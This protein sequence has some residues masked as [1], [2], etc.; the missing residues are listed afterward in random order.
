M[1]GLF[2]ACSAAISSNTTNVLRTSTFCKFSAYRWN[3]SVNH[4]GAGSV[5]F[6]WF[7]NSS[8]IRL[9]SSKGPRRKN[10]RS[11]KSGPTLATTPK[12]NEEGDSF[13]VVRKGDLIGIYKNLSDCQT[14][15]GSSICDPPVSVFKGHSMPKDTEEYLLSRGLKNALYTV[16]AQDV[17]EDLFDTLEPCHLQLSS[18]SGGMPNDHMAKKRS[19][20]AMWPDYTD[21]VAGPAAARPTGSS[22]RKPAML[23]KTDDTALSLGSCSLEFDGASKGNPGQ[24][25]AGAVLRADDGSLTIKLREGLGMTTNNVAEYRAI[26]LGLRCALS[27]GFTRIRAQGDSKLVCMQI[28]GLWKVKNENI[29]TLYEQAKQLKDRFHSFQ[30]VHVLRDSNAEADEQ[31]NLAIHLADGQVQE[32]VA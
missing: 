17:T 1:N 18:S 11:Q 19:Q 29:S 21:D 32:E 7:L 9:Y 12:M 4:V 31:A 5:N 24:A 30:L 14:Q 13:F 8:C 27:K 3:A 28:Q 16:R 2:R 10:S 15:V 6:N 25:G 22:I 20:E 23:E 26:I